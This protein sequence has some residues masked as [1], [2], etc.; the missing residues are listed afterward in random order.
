[1][2]ITSYKNRGMINLPAIRNDMINPQPDSLFGHSV[3]ALYHYPVVE[4][5]A[6]LE[7]IKYKQD[8][9][10]WFYVRSYRELLLLIEEY[11]PKG[12]LPE[13]LFPLNDRGVH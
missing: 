2:A 8:T 7:R 5:L 1:M 4:W 3:R 13:A 10:R 9:L 12:I 6:T 11:V